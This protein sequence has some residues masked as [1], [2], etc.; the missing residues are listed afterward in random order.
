M[1]AVVAGYIERIRASGRYPHLVRM[2]EDDVDPDAAETRDQRF[3]FGLEVI[4]D[5]IG[6]LLARTPLHGR[7]G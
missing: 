2:I 3:E 5:G 1:Q 4:L 6:A 7:P